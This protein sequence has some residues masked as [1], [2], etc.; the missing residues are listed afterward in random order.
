MIQFNNDN[1]ILIQFNNDNPIMIRF[2][3]TIQIMIQYFNSIQDTRHRFFQHDEGFLVNETTKSGFFW[4]HG[5]VFFGAG[6]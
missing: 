5:E 2:N 6:S 4:F 3:D 1:P